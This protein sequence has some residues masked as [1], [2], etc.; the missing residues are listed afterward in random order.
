[1]SRDSWKHNNVGANITDQGFSTTSD[2]LFVVEFSS[3]TIVSKN[4]KV[5]FILLI[6]VGKLDQIFDGVLVF[7]DFNE[8]S[9]DLVLI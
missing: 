6:M 7:D 2:S 3:K 5:E 4:N 8:F 1:V 9:I